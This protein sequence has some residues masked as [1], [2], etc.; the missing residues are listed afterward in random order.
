M[1]ASDIMIDTSSNASNHLTAIAYVDGIKVNIEY[2]GDSKTCWRVDDAYRMPINP[3]DV[4][5]CIV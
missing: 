5:I 2:D 3:S 4:T 1:F